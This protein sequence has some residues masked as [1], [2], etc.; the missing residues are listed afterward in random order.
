VSDRDFRQLYEIFLDNND[1]ENYDG[2]DAIWDAEQDLGFEP[3]EVSEHAGLMALTRAM[4]LSEVTLARMA[5]A[6]FAEPE[7]VVFISGR[8]WSR[9]WEESF[10]K[11]CLVTPFS[12]SSNGF[13][14]LRDLRDLYVHGY[15]I[16][17]NE[18]RR[19]TLAQKLYEAFGDSEPTDEEKALGYHGTSYYF[20]E[21]ARYAPETKSFV[22]AFFWQKNA[23]LSPLST[24]R[25]LIRIQEH[26]TDAHAA[27]GN[28]VREDLS[29]DNSKF[30][31]DFEKWEKRQPKP[32]A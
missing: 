6:W 19:L 14:P 22:S 2:G 11:T 31:R 1:P 8:V 12:T 25:A 10:Y 26:V 4:S 7:E 23:N 13:G 27:L 20:G 32:E 30:V 17:T 5:A 15:G 9:G 3:S 21:Y 29:A 18:D 28:G 24:Y 16:T